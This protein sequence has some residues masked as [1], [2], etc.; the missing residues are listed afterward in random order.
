MGGVAGVHLEVQEKFIRAHYSRVK[1][2]GQEELLIWLK[3]HLQY[4]TNMRSCST[5][6]S[7]LA[8]LSGEFMN[9]NTHLKQMKASSNMIA[10]ATALMIKAELSN[11]FGFH[12]IARET[13]DEVE[14]LGHAIH[15]TYGFTMLCW[16]AGVANFEGFR[17]DRKR[18]YL[19][20]ARKFKKHLRQRVRLGPNAST[21]LRHLQL[22]EDFLHQRNWNHGD[23]RSCYDETLGL[24][25]RRLQH[26]SV[27]GNTCE[28]HFVAAAAFVDGG[29]IAERMGRY[30]DSVRYYERAKMIYV[31]E[32]G[33]F[34]PAAWLEEK[35]EECLRKQ[36]GYNL[37]NVRSPLVGGI[38]QVHVQSS[39]EE[40]P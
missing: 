23:I 36:G 33:A 30:K 6:W 22:K 15:L 10:T 5:H 13:F 2:L 14:S 25:D 40:S 38:V 16:G 34:A 20:K 19:R 7:H 27:D 8:L 4:L 11:T 29:S 9:F 32:C 18:K 21:F 37:C 24:L 26:F 28:P 35:C 12:R 1:S 39:D 17:T 31:E 3:P